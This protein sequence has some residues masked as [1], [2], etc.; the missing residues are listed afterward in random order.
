MLFNSFEFWIFFA[1]VLVLYARVGHAKQNVLL[2]LASYVFYGSWDW[3]F[4]SLVLLSTVVDFVVAQKIEANETEGRRRLW[5]LLS[6][7]TNL[8][9]LGVFKYYDFF[10][11]SLVELLNAMGIGASLPVMKVILPVGI[12][13]YTFQT[14]SY[15]IDVYRRRSKPTRSFVD[16]ALF[17]CFFPQ[18]VAGPIER[19]SDLLPQ[20][21][22]PRP[23]WVEGLREGSYHI[24]IG[25]FKKVVIADNLAEIVDAVFASD[26]STIGGATCLVGVY[27]FAFQ[28]YADFSGYSSMAQG[29]A[30]ILGFDLMFNFRMPYLARD[31]SDFWRR[32]HISLSGWLR[33]YLYI[34]LGGNRGSAWKMYR[35]LMLTMLLGGL[36]HG[37]GWTF[38]AWGAFHG[39]LLCAFRPFSGKS[40]AA[41]GRVRAVVSI[42]VF[43]HLVCVGWLLFRAPTIEYAAAMVARIVTDLSPSS[44]AVSSMLLVSFFTTPL[45][46]YELWVEK[47]GNMLALLEV[48]WPARAAV[49]VYATVMIVTFAPPSRHAFIY[50]Q[51]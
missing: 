18:L 12:S 6:M 39:A 45:F 28:I 5:L 3:R 47:K 10:A 23:R 40:R 26:P 43:F 4:L 38:I 46:L 37:A 41:P 49:Y 8:G 51:F 33:D 9:L 7:A 20:V 16:F 48:S 15:T 1:A 14:M 29:V 2:L 24:V 13:F 35:N 36:W 50:F 32:W 21:Q 34:S 44:F 22:T 19:A 30:K 42:V 11:V 25:L 27:A 31:P 17:V